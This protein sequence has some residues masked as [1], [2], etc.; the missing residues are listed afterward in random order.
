MAQETMTPEERMMAAIRL[1]KPEQVAAYSKRL[2][3][4][5]G[6]DGGLILSSA[7][8]LRR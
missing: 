3:D 7:C 8:T 4:E 2:I 6:G 5:V 1:E